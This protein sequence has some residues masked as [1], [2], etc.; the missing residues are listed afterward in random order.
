MKFSPQYFVILLYFINRVERG[1]SEGEE[2]N[3]YTWTKKLTGV[4]PVD[5]RPSPEK[6]QHFVKKI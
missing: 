3:S 2:L 1:S 5:N 6:L 4:G